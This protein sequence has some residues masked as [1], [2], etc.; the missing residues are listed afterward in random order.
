MTVFAAV[1]VGAFLRVALYV[2]SQGS[3]DIETWTY[4]GQLIQQVGLQQAYE[5]EQVLNHPPLSA[6]WGASALALAH[7]INLPFPLIFKAPSV[8]ADSC[9]VWL[10]GTFFT[11][12]RSS[13]A[14]RAW[15]Y[16]LS[17]PAILITSFHGNTDAIC[18]F[19]VVLSLVLLRQS[20]HSFLGGLVLAC[21][22]NV[23]IIPLILVPAL[24]V[25]LPK[26]ADR[27]RFIGGVALGCVP[28]LAA[29]GLYGEPFVRNVFRY[30]SLLEPWGVNLLLMHDAA[31]TDLYRKLGGVVIIGLI[32]ALSVYQLCKKSFKLEE[33]A[34]VVVCIFLVFAPGF[35]IQYLIYAA[36]LLLLVST[37]SAVWYHLGAGAMALACY[38]SF[39]S[40]WYPLASYH[41][42]PFPS[43][44]ALL[45][46]LAWVSLVVFLYRNLR[47]RL[48][49]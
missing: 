49:G 19:F 42:G 48:L 36:P 7:V 33:I 43:S 16:A 31:A 26:R 27:I 23:K 11:Q 30:K 37:Q 24:V 12:S 32:V 45:G 34:T 47:A 5:R 44:V 10:L 20:Q 4:F 35:G 22:I 13:A 1:F 46:G 41:T 40:S 29:I 15:V 28:I 17:I 14:F 8:L 2:V 9:T 6:W 39:L 3:N 18:V 21:A 38:G 25:T